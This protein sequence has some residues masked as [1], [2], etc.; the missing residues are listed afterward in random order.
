MQIQRLLEIIGKTECS[1]ESYGLHMLYS[2]IHSKTEQLI[3]W[4]DKNLFDLLRNL[5][6]KQHYFGNIDVIPFSMNQIM[7][8]GSE[9]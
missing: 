9:V 8:T 6:F 2:K 4:N 5:P 3:V 1:Q 7:L